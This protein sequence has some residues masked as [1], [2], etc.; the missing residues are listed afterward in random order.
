MIGAPAW[1]LR[2]EGFEAAH[3]RQEYW[4]LMKN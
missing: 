3:Q 4:T 1:G 2:D